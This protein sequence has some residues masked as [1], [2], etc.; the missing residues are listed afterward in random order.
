MD[1]LGRAREVAEEHLVRRE[2]GVLGEEVVL[3]RPR[4]LEAGAVGGLGPGDL[5]A[6]PLGLDGP[7]VGLVLVHLVRACRGC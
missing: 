1:A 3:G 6:Q 5:V 7:L 4:V 2:V